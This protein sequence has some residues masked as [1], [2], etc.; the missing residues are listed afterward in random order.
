MSSR[1]DFLRLIIIGSGAVYAVKL[2]GCKKPSEIRLLTAPKR[3]Y[4]TPKFR[5]AHAYI[6]DG[7][8]LPNISKTESCNVVVIG[9]GISGLTAALT[10][11]QAGKHVVL[12]ESEPQPGGS[13]RSAPL[14]GGKAPLGSV[15]FV[16]RTAELDNLLRFA[17]VE[18]QV[19]PADGYQFERGTVVRELWNDSTLDA[20]VRSGS[21]RDG[22]K[23]F[24]D[25][26]LAL[27]D[28]LPLYPLAA[29]VTPQIL[30]LDVSAEDWIK[31]F[32]SQTLLTVLNAYS[33]S[34]MGAL[35]SRTNVYCL[36][37][38]YASEFGPSLSTPRMTIA[39]GIGRLTEQ[40]AN[41]FNDVRL[42]HLAVRL[43]NTPQGVSVDT[44]N[45][46][47]EI[48]RFNA[49]H[50]VVASQKF[51]AP[52]LIPDLPSAQVQAGKMLSYAPYMTL[53]IVSDMP[54]MEADIFDTWN[55]TSEFET[56][57]VNPRSV[58][59]TSFSKYVSSLYL[60]MDQ[61]ARGQL[62]DS[63][64][65]ARR[66]TD[67]VDRFLASYSEEQQ[68]SVREIY[69]WGWGHSMVIPTPGSH[70]GPAQAASRTFGNIVFANTDCD[71][72]PAIENAA[73]HG[74]RAA[75]EILESKQYGTIK[76]V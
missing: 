1:R 60:P 47:G 3:T 27:G 37:N 35:L 30:S 61:F 25:Y 68:A 28:E 40:A 8:P 24:R 56:D 21:E 72:A 50:V 33:R 12:V 5:I 59:G 75:R 48:V 7:S 41:K 17:N 42:D 70:S 45:D 22:M 55:L 2:G 43:Q 69:C 63:E 54:L 4:S 58:E 9:T 71:A 13:G 57:V 73:Y 53:H 36:Q 26:M 39:G 31:S 15:Y 65:F 66:A 76:Q 19:C 10:L 29:E 18:P 20:V 67:V 51:Q 49:S 38:F 62:Q 74:T 46:E 23:R 64:L 14:G 6:R 34:S 52:Y 32:G 44:I 11:Q 16:E